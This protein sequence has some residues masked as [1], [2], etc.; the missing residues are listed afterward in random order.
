MIPV[1]T[2][3]IIGGFIFIGVEYFLKNRPLAGSI[4]WTATLM[5]AVGQLL[6]AVFP[7]ASR[8][9]STIILTMLCGINRVIATEFSFLVG[10]P[11]MLAAGGLKIFKALRAEVAVDWGFL[12]LG[13]LV[14]GMV[15]FIAVRW[16]LRFVQSHTFIGFGWYRIIV[17]VLLLW[18]L[19]PKQ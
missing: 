11:T 18:I 13:A 14:S 15:S 5:V 7:G 19:W 17:G 4:T 16:L 2:A 6:A 9:G 3:L 1:A 12:L 8:S 10:I